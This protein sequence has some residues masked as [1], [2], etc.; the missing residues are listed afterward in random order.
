MP[1]GPSQ[2]WNQ[3]LKIKWKQEALSSSFLVWVHFRFLFFWQSSAFPAIHVQM[4][5]MPLLP[6]SIASCLLDSLVAVLQMPHIQHLPNHIPYPALN[7][8]S[9]PYAPT[10]GGHHHP[11]SG[12]VTNA[13]SLRVPLDPP[14]ASHHVLVICL[15]GTQIWPFS[16]PPQPPPLAS[17]AVLS[18]SP[19]VLR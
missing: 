3:E 7:L 9:S 5:L 11:P 17:L 12:P 4:S 18:I 8:V 16:K 2:T 14:H 10:H 15:H 1:A 6:N 19:L 13:K